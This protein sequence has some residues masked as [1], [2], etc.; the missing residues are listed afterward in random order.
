[1]EIIDK[2]AP[3]EAHHS[4]G[5]VK[6]YHRPLRQV[7]SIITTKIPGIKPDFALQISFKV[8]NNSVGLNKLVPT[9]LVF[10]AYPKMTKQDAPSL[11][12]IQHAI[13]MQKAIDEV[14]KFTAS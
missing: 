10:D 11:S 2:N 13:A 8:I 6:R 1:M 5:M 9:L 4:I 14:R 12:V 7:Y 3:V